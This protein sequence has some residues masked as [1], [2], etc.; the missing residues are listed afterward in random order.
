MGGSLFW[1]TPRIE[2]LV[3][4]FVQPQ[5]TL[6]RRTFVLKCK[7]LREPAW[8]EQKKLK[9]PLIPILSA[10]DFWE[11]CRRWDVR[12][13]CAPCWRGVVRCLR[14]PDS[15]YIKGLDGA[16]KRIKSL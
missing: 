14:L 12:K 1:T 8:K 6:L 5:S 3:E 13:V 11:T 7:N 10:D 15:R 9:I 2:H 16:Y 4:H